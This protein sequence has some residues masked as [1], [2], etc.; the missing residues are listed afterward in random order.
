MIKPTSE[1]DA[2]DRAQ[3]LA[4][5]KFQSYRDYKILGATDITGL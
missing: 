2:S 4:F 1:E 5:K 3:L